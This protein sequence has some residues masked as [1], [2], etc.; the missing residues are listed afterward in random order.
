LRIYGVI[1]LWLLHFAR[2]TKAAFVI[3]SKDWLYCF[4]RVKKS[5]C[6]A[7]DSSY[8]FSLKERR[9]SERAVRTLLGRV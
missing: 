9:Y 6:Q 4:A 8:S 5:I 7:T 1:S 2:S 3:S